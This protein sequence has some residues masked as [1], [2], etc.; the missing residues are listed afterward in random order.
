V[1][2]LRQITMMTQEKVFKEGEG[3][4]KKVTFEWPRKG[5][6]RVTGGLGKQPT[7]I[8][9]L[10]KGEKRPKGPPRKWNKSWWIS[11]GRPCNE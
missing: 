11:K 4:T 1:K 7:L 3:P 10:K 8:Q 2:S 9:A 5:S 6:T